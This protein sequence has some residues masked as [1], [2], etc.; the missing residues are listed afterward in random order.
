MR[1]GFIGLGNMGGPMALNLIKAG[2]S[3]IVNDV[4]R[5]AAASHPSLGA[6]GRPAPGTWPASELILTSLP[7]PR[8]VEAVALGTDGI[9]H[10][11][12]RDDLR[13]FSTGSPTMMR[14]AYAAFRTRVC[15]C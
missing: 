10:G 11:G 1:I 6:N 9:I 12:H 15:T 13:G 7:G 5:E 14:E 2:H 3:L 4:R 8:E